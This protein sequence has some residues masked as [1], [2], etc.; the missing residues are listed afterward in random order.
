VSV[1]L[2]TSTASSASAQNY[3]FDARRIA[4]GGAAGTPNVASK[5]V[6]R[7]RRY[8]SILIPVGLIKL[9]TDVRVF[10]PTH[11]DFDLSRA[12]EYGTSPLHQ[13]FGRSEDITAGSLFRDIVDRNVNPDLNT[14]RQSGSGIDASTFYEG[15]MS[16]NWGYPFMLHQDDRSFQGL[17]AGA[18]PYLAASAFAEFDGELVD[19]LNGSGDR[20][21][22][23]ASL[24]LGG[25]ETNQL[26]AAITGGYRAR[27]PVFATDGA[28]GRRNGMY[29][30]ANY[31]YL[32]GLRFDSFD[33]QLQL[34][35]DS[36]GLLTPDP[37]EMPFALDWNTSRDGQG[38]ALDFGV[39]FV[40]NR[41]DFGAGVGGV[42]NQITW[43]NIRQNKLSLVSLFNESEW[44]YNK[45]LIGRGTERIELP[46]TYTGDV[47]YHRDQWSLYTEYSR[48]FEGNTFRTGLEYRLAGVELRGA[49]RISQGSWY[50]SGGAG[51][52]LTRNFGVDAALYG[53][54]TFLEPSAHLALALSFRIDRGR[55]GSPPDAA[56]KQVP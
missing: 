2:L 19:I 39:A 44:I 40:R 33:A 6:E 10:F 24:G 9:L 29:V 47:S 46:V 50:P 4:L 52:N 17:Y 18:G 12:V 11:D 7:Q 30:A 13:V 32:Y 37:P 20:Y 27:F 42:A 14:Y 23:A 5:I 54:K 26:A 51:F 21:I 49:G 38:M 15:L 43:K 3:S 31:H 56:P 1:L 22:P 28:G 55:P 25:G 48:G 16:L 35:T 8:T 36:N 41:W 45:Q 34:D 53:T